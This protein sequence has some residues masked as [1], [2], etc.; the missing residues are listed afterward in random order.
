MKLAFW[1]ARSDIALFLKDKSGYAWLFVMPLV[2]T[3]FFG[4]SMGGNG[5]TPAN[6]NPSIVVENLD[7]GLLGARFVR[8][9]ESKGIRMAEPE[10]EDAP[11]RK[12]VIPADFSR[13]IENREKVELI[14]E[15]KEGSHMESAVLL[16]TR[17]LRSM[18]QVVSIL[19]GN[20]VE[21]E[22]APLSEERWDQ[23][24]ARENRI[25]LNA[26]Y[27]GKKPIPS[28]FR[29]SVP[30]Y[31]V[32]FVLMNLL[33]Y[34][35]V[36]VLQERHGGI[37]RRIAIHPVAR[38][39]IV[40]GKIGGL[41]LLGSVQIAFFLITGRF[42]FG[43]EYGE[44]L[45]L[46]ILLLLV[47]AWGCASLGV[48]VGSVLTEQEQVQGLCLLLALVMAALGGCWWPME[49]VPDSIRTLGHAFPTA[50]IMDGLHQLI[51]F[52]GGFQQ[53]TGVLWILAGYAVLFT[54]LSARFLRY[55]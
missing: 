41:F 13:R 53:V 38:W 5:G 52:G 44:R 40:G 55:A 26:S 54:G 12:I 46:L 43:I 30:G 37:L 11:E 50:W 22:A 10:D 1:I 48:L 2:F 42:L 4:M 25:L 28:G 3:Y 23:L 6:P 49:I 16:Q 20:A 15:K 8:V 36:S 19:T 9:M 35:G 14:F 51:S 21:L 39:Q 47:F 32:M 17:L 34:G 29:Q 18:I 27:A 33:M 45:L 7:E 24:A 31:M